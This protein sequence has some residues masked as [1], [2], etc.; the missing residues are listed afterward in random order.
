[1]AVLDHSLDLVRV[2]LIN[3]SEDIVSIDETET[4]MSTLQVVDGLSHVTLCAE[5]Q[6]SKTILGVFDLL[7]FAY[8]VQTLDNLSI[9]QTRVSE[10]CT[11]RLEWLDD[12]VGL[13]AG[14]GEASRA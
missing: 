9:G 2:R 12:L 10:D 3:N 1:M 13:V 4:S 6:S 5:D 11:T 14:K 8:L 7:S